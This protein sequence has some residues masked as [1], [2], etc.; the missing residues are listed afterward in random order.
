M[1]YALLQTGSESENE[2]SSSSDGENY[3]TEL[4]LQEADTSTAEHAP[5]QV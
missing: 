3:Q 5:D 4:G 1:C 2:A